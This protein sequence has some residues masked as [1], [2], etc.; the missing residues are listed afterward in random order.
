MNIDSTSS[1]SLLSSVDGLEKLQQTLELDSGL[2]REFSDTLMEKIKQLNSSVKVDSLTEIGV[3]NIPKNTDKLHGIAAFMSDNQAVVDFNSSIGKG[4]PMVNKF[5]KNI[6][7]E[8]T[9]EALTSVINTLEDVDSDIKLDGLLEKIELVKEA[10]P[11]PSELFEKLDSIGKELQEI[12]KAEMLALDTAPLNLVVAEAPENSKIA[13]ENLLQQRSKLESEDID[14]NLLIKDMLTSIS[15]EDRLEK[16]DAEIQ[17][18]RDFV[19]T[20]NS[21]KNPVDLESQIDIIATGVESI[22]NSLVKNG[23]EKLNEQSELDVDHYQLAASKENRL[24][25]ANQIAAIVATMNEPQV[26]ENEA[27][28]AALPELNTEQKKENLAVINMAEERSLGI[29]AKAESDTLLQQQNTL[30]KQEQENPVIVAKQNENKDFLSDKNPES[31]TDKVLPKFATDIAMLNRAVMT[32]NKS[33]I[34]AM[35]KHFAHPEWNKEISERVIW[36]HKQEIP[37]AELRLNPKHLG[38]ITIKVD[39]SQDQ[40]TVV[41]TAQHVAVKEAIELAIP[42]LREMFSAQQLN[43]AEVN[44]S[45]QDSGQKQSRNFSQMGGEAGGHGHRDD[46]EMANNKHADNAMDIVDEIEAGRAIVS[47]GILSI[48]A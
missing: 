23:S 10:V 28:V 18:L 36:M 43:L 46:K 37:S 1:H 24:Q 41:F 40:A 4:L 7:L 9:L 35:T 27:V 25:V 16:V 29:T 5:E 33:E 32:E 26:R 48:F 6:D 2:S 15:L 45:Q 44:V 38:P 39:V 42:K 31:I 3:F 19:L 17:Q 34:P 47:N 13:K 22:I 11:E 21:L 30:S 14:E 20:E 8:N 12:S